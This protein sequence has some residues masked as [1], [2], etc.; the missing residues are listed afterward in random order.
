MSLVQANCAKAGLAPKESA[1]SATAKTGT[2]N[3]TIVPSTHLLPN[4]NPKF[5]VEKGRK[6]V[7]AAP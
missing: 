3:L 7:S 4:V 2:L 6:E 5:F 1:T